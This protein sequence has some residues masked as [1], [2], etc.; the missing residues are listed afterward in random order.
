ML[1]F[2]PGASWLLVV[3]G[4]QAVSASCLNNIQNNTIGFFS[5]AP[6]T[7]SYKHPSA[8]HCA[9][10]CEKL[11]HC[12]AWLYADPGDCQL[13]RRAALSTASNPNFL[14][15]LC[16]GAS[17]RP[18]PSAS[19]SM[20]SGAVVPTVQMDLIGLLMNMLYD[21][22]LESCCGSPRRHWIC[23]E[24]HMPPKFPTYVLTEQLTA[25]VE[26]AM[27]EA[28]V[29]VID[30]WRR[31]RA[32]SRFPCYQYAGEADR[33]VS[34]HANPTPHLPIEPL[35]SAGPDI[36]RDGFDPQSNRLSALRALQ[37]PYQDWGVNSNST[38]LSG[39]AC[40]ELR[41]EKFIP[42]VDSDDEE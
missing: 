3:A 35:N 8:F 24:G 22:V 19:P 12:Q 2:L 9:F 40:L 5:S 28:D 38:W 37:Y 4:M 11:E 13:Y 1:F 30:H 41:E 21:I 16:D 23:W 25:F 32:M 20:T 7:F 15:G 39:L 26:R 34:P 27:Q 18:S 17:P 36:S 10:K 33:P 14:Y 42:R 29:V 6:L 31:S